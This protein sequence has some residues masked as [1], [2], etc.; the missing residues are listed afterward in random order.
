MGAAAAISY[1]VRASRTAAPRLAR[2]SGRMDLDSR[3]PRGMGGRNAAADHLS[4]GDPT[5]SAFAPGPGRRGAAAGHV[6]LGSSTR[7][8]F[9]AGATGT[10]RRPI[11]SFSTRLAGRSASGGPSLTWIS[12]HDA[13]AAGAAGTQRRPISCLATNSRRLQFA[14]GPWRPGAAAAHVSLGSSPHR[15]AA[16]SRRAR[17]GRSGEVNSQR[18]RA[19]G[20]RGIAAAHLSLRNPTRGAFAAGPGR[21]DY[22]HRPPHRPASGRPA[23]PASALPRGRPDPPRPARPPRP[24]PRPTN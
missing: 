8:A 15:V 21:R 11:Y 7:G 17:P 19:G 1:L 13:R 24:A 9:A 23:H 3:R 14:S 6:S 22:P 10:Q 18:P 2:R 5:R 12:T 20:G 4:L 16:P